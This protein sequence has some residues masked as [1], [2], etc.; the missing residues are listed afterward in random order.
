M[1]GD[2]AGAHASGVHRN[3]LV[4]KAGKPALILGNELR[5]KARLSV[6]RHLQLEL[7]GVRIRVTFLSDKSIERTRDLPYTASPRKA[8][9]G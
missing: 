4:I 9:Y 3:D 1:P 5:I 7:A 2:L 6:P 8:P